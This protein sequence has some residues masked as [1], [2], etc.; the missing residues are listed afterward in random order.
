[1]AKNHG[2]GTA[3]GY[4]NLENALNINLG[5]FNSV[6]VD[7]ANNRLT[8]GGGVLFGDI[9]QPLFEAGKE[10]QTG[11]TV[12]VSMEGATIG[13]GIGFQQGNHGL[14]LD[15]LLS[16]RIVTASGDLVT[17]SKTE[18]AN[19]FWAIRGAGA[20][21]GIVTS[22]TYEIYDQI[23]A[24]NVVLANF[25]Y[26]AATNRSLWELLQTYDGC[27]PQRLA[28]IHSTQY[29]HTTNQASVAV[30]FPFALTILNVTT[31]QMYGI[32][33]KWVCDSGEYHSEYMTGLGKTD[34][35][36]FEAAYDDMV[37]FY[38]A[39]PTLF[40][41]IYP[42][43][44]LDVDVDVLSQ[45][46]LSSFRDHDGFESPRVYINYDHG[47]EGL[48]ALHGA[49]NLPRLRALKAQWDPHGLFGTGNPI[50]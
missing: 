50:K 44:E 13:G 22:A 32:F 30:G 4:G 19:L 17:A 28:L 9:F 6:S 20:N 16:V 23:N 24:G 1:M 15:A 31:T 12:C 43:P 5:N 7:A 47:D 36:T 21:F 10:I 46:L 29:N 27:L 41:H 39:H 34:V 33:S 45:S 14:I 25:Q 40:D 42:G 18:N 3:L 8:V 2:H 38:E 35:A 48:A 37:S 49:G 11:N 26:P